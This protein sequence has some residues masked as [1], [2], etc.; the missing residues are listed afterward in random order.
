MIMVMTMR[1]WRPPF[2]LGQ[3]RPA[4]V[5]ILPRSKDLTRSRGKLWSVSTPLHKPT[6]SAPPHTGNAGLHAPTPVT[7]LSISAVRTFV[8]GKGFPSQGYLQFNKQTALKEQKLMV[9]FQVSLGGWSEVL[10]LG[11]KAL[12]LYPKTGA[13]AAGLIRIKEW[14]QTRVPSPHSW[15]QNKNPQNGQDSEWTAGRNPQREDGEEIY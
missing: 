7:S 6:A 8:H 13:Q 9:G 15:G 1:I 12:L 14:H 2:L 5:V 3:R 10:G 11:Y 4:W